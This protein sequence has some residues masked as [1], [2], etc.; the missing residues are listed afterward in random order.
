MKIE[1]ILNLAISMHAN[2]GVYALLLG[3]GVSRSAGIFTG[4]EIVLDLVTRIAHLQGQT[5]VSAGELREAE[6]LID[7]I[8]AE[9]FRPWLKREID[10]LAA[11][12]V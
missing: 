10:A 6:N 3:S 2:P 12:A 1:P 8:G 5:D 9:V 7:D 4:W 11:L